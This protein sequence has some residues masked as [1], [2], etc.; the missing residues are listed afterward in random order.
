MLQARE[1][2]YIVPL[3]ATPNLMGSFLS[4]LVLT[5]LAPAGVTI[6]F[7][8]RSFSALPPLMAQVYVPAKVRPMKYA[9]STGMEG[10]P[11]MTHC[12]FVN[13]CLIVRLFNSI[14]KFNVHIRRAFQPWKGR[15]GSSKLL[16]FVSYVDSAE[17][18]ISVKLLSTEK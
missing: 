18:I 8:E 15:R 1:P 13:S 3:L 11:F 5:T 6:Q 9:I 16:G 10:L 17:Y 7:L 14:S 12:S 4:S 2:D